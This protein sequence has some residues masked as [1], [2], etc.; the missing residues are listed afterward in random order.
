MPGLGRREV[1][2]QRAEP[3][4]HC[5][6]DER[7]DAKEEEE[8]LVET[9]QVAAAATVRLSVA[10]AAQVQ[11]GEPV[12]AR[13]RELGVAVARAHVGVGDGRRQVRREGAPRHPRHGRGQ[14]AGRQREPQVRLVLDQV[15]VR[16]QEAE[17]GAAEGE[18]GGNSG[19]L[20]G[21]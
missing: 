5:I 12:E 18:G 17:G 6:Q 20:G 2:R 10:E 19:L 21:V 15:C 3:N 9:A 13:Q 1:R 16:A 8:W 4:L 11:L 14:Q 7:Q